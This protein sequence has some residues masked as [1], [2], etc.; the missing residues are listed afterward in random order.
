VKWVGRSVIE[1]TEFGSNAELTYD[2]EHLGMQGSHHLSNLKRMR[3]NPEPQIHYQIR[4]RS[5]SCSKSRSLMVLL[6]IV[7]QFTE[8]MS[9]VSKVYDVHK[10][11]VML[12][13]DASS[14]HVL[15][16]LT[17]FSHQRSFVIHCN[18]ASDSNCTW[19]KWSESFF[20]VVYYPWCYFDAF[21]E[22]RWEVGFWSL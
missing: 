15:V 3:E 18:L 1:Q 16:W 19:M 21:N 8:M 7:N 20:F 4:F 2:V 10:C 11:D 5:Q 12:R 6:F 9:V 14:C 22:K 17:G 13:R